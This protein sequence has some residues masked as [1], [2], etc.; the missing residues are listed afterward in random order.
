M[1]RLRGHHLVCLHYYSGG[2]INERFAGNLRQKVDLARNGATILIAGGADDI[3]RACPHLQQN[4]CQGRTE[5]EEEIL[6]LDR[7]ALE[8][9][10]CSVGQ[11]VNW[12]DIRCQVE[13]ASPS[14]F[15]A[16]CYG[17]TW[18]KYCERG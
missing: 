4:I 14:W 9:L 8:L 6:Q 11:K 12:D 10:N 5:E 2:G 13:S 16:F 15:K 18:A 7:Q 3:C 1:I 17:C